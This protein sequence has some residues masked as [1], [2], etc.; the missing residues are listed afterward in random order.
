MT[1]RRSSNSVVVWSS[2][3]E[4][5]EA[6]VADLAARLRSAHPELRRIVWFGSWIDGRPGPW[7]DVDL[8]LVLERSDKRFRDRIPDYLPDRFPLPLD[9]FPYTE[10]ELARL[11]LESPGWHRQILRGRDV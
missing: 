2:N 1:R 3:R 9:V 11:A 8:C 6:A 5:A 10:K 7:S 4:A